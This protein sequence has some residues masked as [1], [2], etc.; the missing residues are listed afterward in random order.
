MV[1]I[2][3]PQRFLDCTFLLFLFPFTTTIT[4]TSMNPYKLELKGKGKG[5]V[6]VKFDYYPLL[7]LVLYLSKYFY[8]LSPIPLDQVHLSIRRTLLEEVLSHVEGRRASANDSDFTHLHT[9]TSGAKT[10]PKSI[11]NATMLRA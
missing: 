11:I 2:F 4:T 8:H 1:Q 7:T 6:G 5:D 10:I 9:S 3:P